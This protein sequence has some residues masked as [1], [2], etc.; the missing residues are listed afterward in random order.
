MFYHCWTRKEAYIKARGLGLSLGLS[1]FSVPLDSD[2]N[3]YFSIDGHEDVEAWRWRLRQ[4]DPGEGYAATV[5][6]E[7]TDWSLELWQYQMENE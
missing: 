6:T 1:T 4:L 7:G 3:A 2:L 5:V